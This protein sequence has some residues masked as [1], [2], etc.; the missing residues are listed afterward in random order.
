MDLFGIW[1]LTLFPIG[2]IVI[3]LV[4]LYN[5]HQKGMGGSQINHFYFVRGNKQT[6]YYKEEKEK[7][8]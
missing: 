6:G 4:H 1:S 2:A 8:F 7:K 5:D 3:R